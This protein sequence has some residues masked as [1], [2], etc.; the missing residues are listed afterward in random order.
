MD[1]YLELEMTR[2][3]AV[4]LSD[5]II[6]CSMEEPKSGSQTILNKVCEAALAHAIEDEPR[7]HSF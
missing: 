1:D 7:P 6:N 3:A 4:K 2:E 5:E